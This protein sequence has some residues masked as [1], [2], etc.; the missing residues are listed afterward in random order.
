[1]K[2]SNS[3]KKNPN[4]HEHQSPERVRPVESPGQ[5]SSVKNMPSSVVG[6]P[7]GAN[8]RG[9]GNVSPSGPGQWSSVKGTGDTAGRGTSTG[10]AAKGN[11]SPS[12]PGQWSTFV[13]GVVKQA[14]PPK[15]F[16]D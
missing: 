4:A 10:D 7:N 13:E 1:M 3:G 8:V 6:P 15:G 9:A 11:P 2:S 16:S 14:A 12:A 5:W